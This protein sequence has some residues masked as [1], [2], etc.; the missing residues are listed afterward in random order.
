MNRSLSV[1]VPS[2][3]NLFVRLK[4]LVAARKEQ[5]MNRR[6]LARTERDAARIA[7]ARDGLSID[8]ARFRAGSPRPAGHADYEVMRQIR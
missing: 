2:D 7:L 1:A 8:S 3:D 5:T 6:R 4:R